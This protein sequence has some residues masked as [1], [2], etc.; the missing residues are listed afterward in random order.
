MLFVGSDD[1][2]S[3]ATA[4]VFMV[5]AGIST[6]LFG[7]LTNLPFIVAPSVLYCRRKIG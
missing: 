4:E 2:D 3:E 7:L 5:V 1:L 6:I